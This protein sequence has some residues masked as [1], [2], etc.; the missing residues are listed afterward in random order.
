ML[1]HSLSCW[2]S[3]QV[4]LALTGAEGEDSCACRELS[5]KVWR[6]EKWE[7][8]VPRNSICKVWDKQQESQP[9]TQAH[10]N[11]VWQSCFV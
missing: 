5:A 6:T 3:G 9:C 7:V 11:E 10:Q 4:R 1:R 8:Q 2:D